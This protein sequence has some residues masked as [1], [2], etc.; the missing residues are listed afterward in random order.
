MKGAE[1]WGVECDNDPGV[2]TRSDGGWGVMRT[3]LCSE[4]C[5]LSGCILSDA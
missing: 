1:V 2:N 3:C 4:G 5:F